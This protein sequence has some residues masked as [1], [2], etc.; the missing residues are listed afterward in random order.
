M[1]IKKYPEL[2]VLALDGAVGSYITGRI[3]A[4]EM[5][6]FARAF[7]EGCY[8]PDCRPPFPSITPT[9]WAS[10]ATATTPDRH[11]AVDQEIHPEGSGIGVL[12]SAY[13]STN[14]LGQR[15]WEAAAESGKTSLLINYPIAS[16]AD[17]NRN[18]K[19]LIAMG[20]GYFMNGLDVGCKTGLEIPYQFF[21]YSPRGG[22]NREADLN[23]RIFTPSGPWQPSNPAFSNKAEKIGENIFILKVHFN[24]TNNNI[25]GVESFS[26]F[27]RLTADGIVLCFTKEDLDRN[28]GIVIPAGGWSPVFTR[29][30][31]NTDGSFSYPFRAKLIYHED[32]AFTLYIRGTADMRRLAWPR[33]FAETLN[34][35]DVLP[36]GDI[37]FDFVNLQTGSDGLIEIQRMNFDWQ[38]KIISETLAKRELDIVVSYEGYP[39][40][41]NHMFRSILEGVDVRGASES[42]KA[43]EFYRRT[44]DLADEYLGWLYEHILGPETTLL[45]ISDHG[46]VGFDRTINPFVVLEKAGLLYYRT[47][48]DGSKVIDPSKTIAWPF[49][50]GHVYINLKGRD[51][52]GIVEPEDYERT[53][54]RVIAALQDGFRDQ[55]TGL[56]ALAFAV[57]RDQAGFAGLGGDRAGDV[58]YGLMGSRIGGAIGG[59]HACQIPTART[60]TGD[61]RALCVIAGPGFKKNEIVS[62]PINNYDIIPT[63][64]DRLGYPQPADATGAIAFQ[65]FLPKQGEE[66]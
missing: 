18:D 51:P 29:T 50:S 10:L 63:V 5:P 41:V 48:G 24:G 4:G 33:E 64:F 34:F 31:K 9:C 32:G 40:G 17:S 21:T 38:K 53:V 60:A 47:R 62:R 30:L 8:F 61:I 36:S 43:E 54:H 26:W 46:A 15:F 6:S 13:H 28:K 44:Y 25:C 27:V 19:V 2:F 1:A 42:A 3:K 59:V 55:D 7:R 11:G 52:G 66:R 23:T 49:N 58:V 14:T 65:A 56:C 37:S 35:P 20:H 45:I 39:D 12:T 57:P 22:Q 16:P